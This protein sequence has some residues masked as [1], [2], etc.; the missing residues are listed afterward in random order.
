MSSGGRCGGGTFTS[1]TITPAIVYFP[2]GYAFMLK[3]LLSLGFTY[4]LLTLLQNVQSFLS[5]WNILLYTDYCWC[6]QP[7]YPTCCSKLCRYGSNRYVRDSQPIFPYPYSF[8]HV[9]ML[10]STTRCWPIHPWRW[11]CTVVCQ[12]KQLLPKCSQFRDRSSTNASLSIG[13]GFALAS[14]P[15]DVVD[16]YPS[17]DEHRG[18]E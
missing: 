15:S 14:F 10:L 17:R 11:R 1:S 2:R 9:F 18:R 16:E 6:S 13:Y 7:T 4:P 12:P 5:H 8:W 3:L